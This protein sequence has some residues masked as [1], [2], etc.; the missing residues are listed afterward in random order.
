MAISF[1]LVEEKPKSLRVKRGRKSFFTPEG[2]VALA[3]L[4][5][6]T[7]LSA[8]KLMEALNGNIHYQ[9]FCGIR[10]SPENQ[11]TNYKLIDSILLELSRKLKIQEQQKLLA[12]AWK[13]HMKNLD[14]M[15]TDA[16]CYESHTVYHGVTQ[17]PQIHPL[18]NIRPKRCT[19][20]DQG[21]LLFGILVYL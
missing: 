1:G 7:G 2:K 11:L 19:T 21:M 10:I 13:P 17:C 16:S 8:P 6:Y 3:F 20:G 5:M 14:T 15:C 12:D 9:I 4:K 18:C